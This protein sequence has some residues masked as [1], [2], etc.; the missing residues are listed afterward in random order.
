MAVLTD[1]NQP[2]GSAIGNAWEVREA[3]EALSGLVPPE[4]PLMQVSL[5]LGSAMLLLSGL[6]ASMEEGKEKL[7]GAINNGAGLSVLKNMISD[8]G[9]DESYIDAE[10]IKKNTE[11]KLVIPVCAEISGYVSGMDTE[12]IGNA[13]RVLG[14]GRAK[15]TDVIDPAVGIVF[16]KRLG[17]QVNTGDIVCTV[18]ANDEAKAAEAV[19]MIR[20]A[21][22]FSDKPVAAPQ[23]ILDVIKE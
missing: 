17:E 1:M 22:R 14:A 15:L 8:L 5:T 6:C 9:G 21:V 18:Y 11:T 13:S 19:K 20:E 2:L 4:A 10:K 3:V 12:E 16:S 7:L 23:L